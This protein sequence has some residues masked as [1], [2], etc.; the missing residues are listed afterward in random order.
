MNFYYGLNN[1]YI[2]ITEQINKKFLSNVLFIP[3]NDY[4]R[5][6]KF[7]LFIDNHIGKK[8]HILIK[9]YINKKE[10]ILDNDKCYLLI[11]KEVNKC[12]KI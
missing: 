9:D 3:E 11:K 6:I 8:K 5:F 12:T 7:N 10:Y 4:I 1:D 2:D